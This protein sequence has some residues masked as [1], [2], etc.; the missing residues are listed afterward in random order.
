MT[1]QLVTNAINALSAVVARDNA[2]GTPTVSTAA[3]TTTAASVLAAN[4]SRKVAILYNN[5][6]QAVY[7]GTTSGVTVANGMPLVPGASFIDDRTL[8]AWYGITPSG[9][10]DLRIMQVV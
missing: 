6:A 1:D 8:G 5:G 10:G 9:T 7:L 2:T 3:P 4:S